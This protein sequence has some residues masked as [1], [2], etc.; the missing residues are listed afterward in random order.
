MFIWVS[1]AADGCCRHS[2]VSAPLFGAFSLIVIIVAPREACTVLTS[3]HPLFRSSASSVSF[4]FCL[5]HKPTNGT[6]KERIMVASAAFSLRQQRDLLAAAESHLGRE[7]DST[8]EMKRVVLDGL[9]RHADDALRTLRQR[10][11][12]KVVQLFVLFP[13]A[14]SIPPISDHSTAPL[15]GE[16]VSV[17]SQR[18][19]GTARQGSRG[20]GLRGAATVSG[21]STLLDLPLPNNGDYS[22]EFS[23]MGKLSVR[24]RCFLVGLSLL[25]HTV[26]DPSLRADRIFCD[27]AVKQK[28]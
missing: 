28:V 21:V 17:G 22:R 12:R 14:A 27:D 18:G 5:G 23:C 16:G 24:G 2:L 10:R 8:Q 19:M 9:R 15:D 7:T 26:N 1:C 6:R 11:W 20:V 3:S 13:V 25:L 4:C